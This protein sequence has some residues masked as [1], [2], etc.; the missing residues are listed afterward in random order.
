MKVN[1]PALELLNE[2]LLNVIL[3]IPT[4]SLA[5]AV[6]ITVCFL[7]D[8]FSSTAFPVALLV[9]ELIV[10]SWL[11]ALLILIV[12]LSVELLPAASDTV[13]VR[14]SVLEPKL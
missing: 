12:T 11:S 13:N 4:L 6:K 3:S 5:T 10:G 1:V 2:A 7:S 14:L 8:D 9:N